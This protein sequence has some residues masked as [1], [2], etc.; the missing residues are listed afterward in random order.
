MHVY[1][2]TVKV[3]AVAPPE[4][5]GRVK[6]VI[7]TIAQTFFPGQSDDADGMTVDVRVAYADDTPV[8]VYRDHELL[9]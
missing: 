3:L 2:V 8:H 7:Q 9:H 4:Q 6:A 5:A 1:E